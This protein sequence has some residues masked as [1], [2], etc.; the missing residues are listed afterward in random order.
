MNCRFLFADRVGKIYSQL[1]THQ[2]PRSEKIRKAKFIVGILQELIAKRGQLFATLT[3][4]A[5]GP[6]FD[7]AAESAHM[8]SPYLSI[9]AASIAHRVP[10]QIV[11][12]SH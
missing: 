8:I 9:S 3:P 5:F 10:C 12:Q 4:Q 1:S 11:S 2:M 7:S 6:S